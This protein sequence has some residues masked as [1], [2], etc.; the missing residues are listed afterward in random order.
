MPSSDPEANWVVKRLPRPQQAKSKKKPKL[1]EPPP[2]CGQLDAT[3]KHRKNNRDELLKCPLL[4]L[5]CRED[6]GGV[7]VSGSDNSSDDGC[8]SDLSNISHRLDH[9]DAPK[10]VYMESLGSQGAFPKPMNEARYDGRLSLADEMLERIKAKKK[11]KN[12]PKLQLVPVIDIINVSSGSSVS[13]P[14]HESR[15]RTAVLQDACQSPGS[16]QLLARRFQVTYHIIYSAVS[17]HAP[18][19]HHAGRHQFDTAMR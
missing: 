1:K 19:M 14:S 13:S 4:A 8:E 17:Y 7:S 11:A 9:P 15:F 6:R 3:G 16:G 12:M 5:Q 10:H 18:Q 2:K